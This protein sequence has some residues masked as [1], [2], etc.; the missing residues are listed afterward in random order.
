MTYKIDTKK[1]EATVSA[2]TKTKKTLIVLDT[3]KVGK[4]KYAVTT[5]WKKSL[6]GSNA[7]GI[8][9]GK[10]VKTIGSE[11]FADNKKLKWIDINSTKITKVGKDA[12]RGIKKDTMILCPKQCKEKYQ[13]MFE[14]AGLP[15]GMKIKWF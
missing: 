12:F 6:Q 3:V 5:V 8:F 7:Q 2:F 11:A 1:K 13:T 9:L 14:Q 10:N 4:K 15:K